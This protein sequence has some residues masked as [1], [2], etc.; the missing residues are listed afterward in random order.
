MPLSDKKAAAERAPLSRF[1]LPYILPR[2]GP[3]TAR[4]LY[5]EGAYICPKG[6]LAM[7]HYICPKGSPSPK[8]TD[9]SRRRE[10]RLSDR[11]EKR[12]PLV[13]SVVSF[14]SSALRPASGRKQSGTKRDAL[15][16]KLSGPLGLYCVPLAGEPKTARALWPLWA[17]STPTLS[18]YA[19]W[20]ARALWAYIA[21]PKGRRRCVS[22]CRAQRA[23]LGIYCG[24]RKR[25]TTPLWAIYAEAATTTIYCKL[26]LF[27]VS[28]SIKSTIGK[29]LYYPIGG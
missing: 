26:K 6:R 25:A 22:L 27:K 11:E 12:S 2:R 21:S 13:L 7:S 10:R 15:W 24:K 14:S 16:A 23:P 8:G 19:G 5:S 28:I 20:D 1:A 29:A 17:P 3:K 4:A 18:C 9:R